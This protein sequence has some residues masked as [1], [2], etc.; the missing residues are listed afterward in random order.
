M[1]LIHDF[2]TIQTC[3]S[4]QLNLSSK[5]SPGQLIAMVNVS[6]GFSILRVVQVLYAVDA[7]RRD[8][9]LGAV[10][11]LQF[12]VVVS[13]L[14]SEYNVETTLERMPHSDAR[15]VIGAEADICTM[16]LPSQSLR[17]RDP[18]QHT[19]ILFASARDMQYC[20]ERNSKLQLC[21]ITEVSEVS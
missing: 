18:D 1:N 10:G 5:H 15:R 11:D 2:D 3:S 4:N 20:R 17:T 21:T 14:A 19:V 9:V 13:R 6:R 12:E 7:G 8:P 16:Y